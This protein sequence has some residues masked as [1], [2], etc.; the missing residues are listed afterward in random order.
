M[1]K[2]IN[3]ALSLILILS[4]AGCVPPLIRAANDGDIKK[5]TGLLDNG[6]DVNVSINKYTSLMYASMQG[7]PDMVKLLL[8]RG[9]D[10]NAQGADRSTA[11]L[12]AVDKGYPVIIQTLLAKGADP[13]IKGQFG[14]YGG[15][16]LSSLELAEKRGN[17][18]IVQML[19]AAQ[20]KYVYKAKNEHMLLIAVIDFE[21]KGLSRQDAA[22]VS[23]WLRTEL[24]NTNQ[25]R[26]I[27]RSA[28]NAILKEQAFAMPG[29]TDTSCAVQV[30]KLLSARKMLVGS[31]EYWN[32][33]VIING[34]IIDVEKGVAEFA[35]RETV[36]SIKELDTGATSF[37][38][39]LARRINGLP[40]E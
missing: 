11:L 33:K 8:D 14:R 35:H 32:N 9:A 28:M 25:F 20:T 27:E 39:N 4:L 16:I 1:A 17:T 34:R 6:A 3:F 15:E 36:N 37:A 38:K 19:K 18:Q 24:I 5:A 13:N 2:T 22:R 23:E 31:V 7:K 12:F 21:P 26:V 40:V 10:V 29:C 30:G